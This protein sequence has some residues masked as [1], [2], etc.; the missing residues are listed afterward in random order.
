MPRLKVSE[1]GPH[2]VDSYVGQKVKSRRLML[3]MSQQDLAHSVGL[4]FQQIQKYERGTNRISVSRLTEISA[5]LKTPLDY[6][7]EGTPRLLPGKKLLLKSPANK[8]SDVD[9]LLDRDV[10]QLV[11]S[12]L[13]IKK[14]ALKKQLLQMARAISKERK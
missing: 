8:Q 12:Y 11:R 4:T 10:R 14:P 9:P 3:G 1:E 5:A 6:F 13:S 7:L 2:P